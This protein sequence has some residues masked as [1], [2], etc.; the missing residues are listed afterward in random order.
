MAL[1][2]ATLAPTRFPKRLLMAL[3]LTLIVLTVMTLG[4]IIGPISLSFNDIFA[5]VTG[6]ASQTSQAIVT[7]IR[8]PRVVIGLCV[9]VGLALAGGAMQGMLRNPLADPGLVGVTGGASLGAVVVIVL[10]ERLF[11]GI[12]D[13]LRPYM[14]PIAAFIGASVVTTLVFAISRNG[15]RTSV[16]T[17]IL[18]GVAVNS[19]A[20]AAIGV[21]VYISDDNQLRDLTF[22]SMGSLARSDW[23]V[24]IITL[25]VTAL[26]SVAFLRLTRALDLFQIGE[27]AA[28]HAGLDVEK[29][30]FRAGVLTAIVVGTITAA[31]GPIGFIGLI[32]PHMARAIMGAAHKWMMPAAALIGTVLILVADLGV[33][34]AVPPA[35]PPIGLATSL[36]GGPFFLYLLLSTMKA[37]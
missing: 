28:F 4:V 12:P 35:E 11:S 10:G 25:I 20:G 14:L 9:G 7:Q 16:A 26:C 32:A 34:M 27:R 24:V 23:T 21:M 19:I 1:A 6:D 17:L 15:G 18:A 13:P 30:K 5:A 36:I 31:V 33:R 37:R 2:D 8:A 22:W 3:G 29:I